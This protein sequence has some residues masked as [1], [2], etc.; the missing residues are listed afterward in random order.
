MPMNVRI[1]ALVA[2]AWLSGPAIAEEADKGDKSR[3]TL[4]DPTPV[5]K[6]REFDPDRPG[7]SHDPATID[8]GHVQFETGAFEHVFD[9]RARSVGSTRRYS[10]GDTYARIGVTNDTEVQVGAPIGNLLRM[11]G[12]DPS[13]ARGFGD[14]TVA[15][16]TN[17]IGNDGG[18]HILAIYPSLKVPTA[19]RGLGNDHVE[20]MVSIPY[21][22][23]ILDSLLLT[24]EPSAGVLR[25]TANTRYR[26]AYGM[27]V[28]FDAIIAKTLIASVEVATQTSTAGKERTMWGVS[29]SLAVIVDKNLQLDCGAVLGLNKATP[30]Y[31]PYVGISARF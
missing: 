8:A 9:P 15:M 22:Y 14:T 31:S 21:N 27:I 24:L 19:A 13:Q 11:G 23:K 16:K 20:G 12:D 25:D 7:L 10:F 28:G 5:A 30:R 2:V 6:L 18:N 26:D 29:P 1:A 3:Y 4:F 17:L